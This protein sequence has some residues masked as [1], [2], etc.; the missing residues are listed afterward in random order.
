MAFEISTMADLT[1]LIQGN[2]FVILKFFTPTCP[3]CKKLA[4][5]IDLLSEDL[6]QIT[7]LQVNCHSD[8]DIAKAFEIGAVPVLIYFN[9]GKI[10]GKTM[11]ADEAE[12][13]TSIRT[14]FNLNLK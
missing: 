10:V 9:N 11:G 4:P 3:P 1:S 6:Q 14:L 13:K 8:N 7:F 12:I 2:T 5:F